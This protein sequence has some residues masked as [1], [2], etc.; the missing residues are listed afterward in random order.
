MSDITPKGFANTRELMRFLISDGTLRASPVLPL[1][2][3]ASFSRAFLIFVINATAA[4]PSFSPKTIT[5]LGLSL[6][7]TLVFAHMS[8]I[9]SHTLVESL[10]LKLRMNMSHLLLRSDVGLLQRRDHGQIQAVA[11]QEINRV[12]RSAL[13]LVEMIQ[14]AL[15]LVL[16][17]LYMFWLSWPSGIATLIAIAVGGGGFVLAERPARQL[18]QK[19]NMAAAEFF[20]RI[21][22][23]LRGY[24]ELRLREERRQAIEKHTSESVN[25]VRT[26]SIAAERYFSLGESVTQASVILLL[27]GIVLG[28]P[29]L[30]GTPTITVL[31]ILTVVLFAYGPI[32]IVIGGLSDLARATVSKRMVDRLQDEFAKQA[33]PPQISAGFS[34]KAQF[35]TLELRD[36]TAHLSRQAKADNTQARDH[37][38]LG[39]INLIF[40]PGTSVFITGGNGTGKSTLLQ[41]LTG[42]SHPDGGEIR[43]DG[44]AVTPTTIADYRGLFSAVFSE[45]YLFQT[46]YGLQKGEAE[47]L[48]RII[49]ELGLSRV[50]Q[51]EGNHFASLA[52]S[53]GQMRRLAL[54]LALAEERPI[55]VLD[56]FAADQDPERRRFFYDELIPALTAAGRL[57][58]AVTH[59]EHCFDKC[60][61]LIRMEDGKIV[62][63]SAGDPSAQTAT[64]VEKEALKG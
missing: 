40:H 10:Q 12:A 52:L 3:F 34:E 14:A 39:P 38:T 44:T 11:T 56:E 29:L 27:F 45:F 32:E 50:V 5:I 55:V 17:V 57:V 19:A 9:S 47:R 54:A 62:Y 31:Q 48:E 41:L 24:K 22:D 36:I 16:C 21:N 37:F 4:N 51:I 13:K 30:F 2:I 33:E 1:V 58:L 7:A 28:L 60:D 53:T 46:L 26:H 49:G 6:T 64:L 35:S 25:R 61:R 15:L 18:V 23:M 43:L 63:D 59:D 42:L 20:S 8:R